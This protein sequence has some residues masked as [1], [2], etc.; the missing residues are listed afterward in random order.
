MASNRFPTGK[1]CLGDKCRFPNLE[2][3]KEHTCPACGGIVHILCGVYDDIID[4]YVCFDCN[5]AYSGGEHPVPE[6]TTKPSAS[7][8]SLK[9]P[10]LPPPKEYNNPSPPKKTRKKAVKKVNN[11]GQLV[12]AS[13]GNVGHERKSSLLCPLNPKSKRSVATAI[14]PVN[15]ITTTNKTR[16]TSTSKKNTTTNELGNNEDDNNTT[17]S[18]LTCAIATT[19]TESV[20]YKPK[21]I[22]LTPNSKEKMKPV[23]DISH[24]SFKPQPTIFKT[25]SKDYRGRTVEIVPTPKELTDRYYP[26]T[27]IKSI[28]DNS[29]A[30]CE[31][32]KKKN[33]NL[34]H[35][36]NENYSKPITTACIYQF[37]AIIYYFGIVRLP[38]KRDYWSKESWMPH[39]PIVREMGMTR[40]RFEFLWR[41]FHVNHIEEN[42]EEDDDDGGEELMDEMVDENSTRDDSVMVEQ[43]MERVQMD[44]EEETV[45]TS[46]EKEEESKASE[47][48]NE[49]DGDTWFSK[50]KPLV[51]HVRDVSF[52]LVFILGTILSLDEMMIRFMGR[53]AETHRMKNKPI[54]EG[55]KFFVLATKE[56]FIVNFTPDGR[57]A[58]KNNKQEYDTHNSSSGKIEKMILFVMKIIDKFKERQQERIRGYA[59]ANRRENNEGENAYQRDDV[60]GVMDKF[61]LGIDNYFSVPKVIK[62]LRDMGVGIVGTARFRSGWPPEI[63]RKVDQT[64]C[65]FNDFHYMLDE[66]GTLVARWMD[67]GLVFCVSTLH[68]VGETI[69]RKRRRPRVTGKNKNHV[70]AV[71]GDDGVKAIHIPTLID[72]YNHWMGGVDVADQ[73]IAYYQPDL[74]CHRTWLPMFLQIM[75]II[76]SNAFIVYKSCSVMKSMTHKQF[77]LEMISILMENA[78][79]EYEKDSPSRG[80]TQRAGRPRKRSRVVLST[81]GTPDTTFQSTKVSSP[82]YQE[83]SSAPKKT[84]R[85]RITKCQVLSHPSGAPDSF[86]SSFRC[87]KQK[88]DHLHCRVSGT[89]YKKP[90]SCIYCSYLFMKRKTAG[91]ELEYDKEVKR[92]A[93][94]CL[95]CTKNSSTNSNCFLCK[96]HF[97]IFHKS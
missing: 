82:E 2:L 64:K 13:C 21:F 50:L 20:L 27:F 26:L 79:E 43:D 73:R 10:P 74:R 37:L 44:Q 19:A 80:P 5:T 75:S 52:E 72:D 61:C 25:F 93:M 18:S 11:K 84:I 60:A 34:Y 42:A 57:T 85:R 24:S 47:N 58:E 92:T 39:H 4:K 49:K 30:Y 67:N 89:D 66:Q 38:S 88:P 96:E 94:I 7:S 6:P 77:T 86:F 83:N 70:K 90:G 8:T 55:F 68:K 62:K 31:Y 71:W 29:N 9:P 23:I 69:L 81:D 65:E 22:N 51:D 41:F 54:S 87:R 97:E 59:R 56:G 3:R 48:D 46:E 45:S 33:P 17:T 14:L 35:W 1:C 28:R 76:R 78:R 16:G 91:E 36:R 15:A 63:L 53:S 95:F 32:Q 40:Y 12:C